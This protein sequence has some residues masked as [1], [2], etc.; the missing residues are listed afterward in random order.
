MVNNILTPDFKRW[1]SG[2]TSKG[3]NTRRDL[4]ARKETRMFASTLLLLT[5]LIALGSIVLAARPLK[6]EN[7]FYC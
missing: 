4:L 6:R 7:P 1:H 3:R 5:A 2:C